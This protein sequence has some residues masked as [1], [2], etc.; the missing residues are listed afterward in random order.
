MPK[1]LLHILL[2]TVLF[3]NG[4][5]E[6]ENEII[7]HIHDA[8]IKVSVYRIQVNPSGVTVI[9]PIIN[10][11][12]DLF[13]TEFDRTQNQNRILAGVTDSSGVFQFYNLTKEYYYIR[14]SHPTYGE[15]LEETATPDGT[16]SFV[17][18]EF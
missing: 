14:A 5:T 6:G 18:C 3:V 8:T 4:C 13:E 16:V 11:A 7:T 15:R 9:I 2:F 12:V 10:A 1:R 17:N